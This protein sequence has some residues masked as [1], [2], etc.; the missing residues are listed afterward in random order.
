M[1]TAHCVGTLFETTIALGILA[2]I[3]GATLGVSGMAAHASADA[4]ARIVLQDAAER[5]MHIALDVLKY[6]GGAL[7]PVSI[8]TA[9]PLASS[10]PL[11]VQ[12][13][14][15]SSVTASGATAVTISVTETNDSTQRVIVEGTLDRRAPL[16]GTTLR[17]PGLVPAPTGAP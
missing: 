1:G 15:S 2:T 14:L 5:E 7:A 12:M 16:P 17:A 8:A 13:S 10:S 6:R 3:A 4:A 9:L 11:P